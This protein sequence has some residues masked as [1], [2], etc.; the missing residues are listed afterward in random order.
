MSDELRDRPDDSAS[1]AL[2][3]AVRR[4]LRPLVRF[5]LERQLGF[6]FLANLLKGLYVEVAERDVALPGRRPTDSRISLLTGIHRREV[7]RLRAQLRREERIPSVLTLGALLVSRWT[8]EPEYLDAEGR[9]RALPRR[10]PAPAPSFESLVA[11]VSTDLPPRSVLDEWLRLGV[12]SED[13]N[14]M[15]RLSVDSFVP[16]KGFEEKVHFFGR[17]L[18]DHIAAGAHNILEAGP[19]FLDRSVYYDRLSQASADELARMAREEGA[20]LIRRVNRRALELQ[21]E[22]AEETR[23]TTHRMTLGAYFYA[24]DERNESEDDDSD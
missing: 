15:L 17:N 22:D 12:V 11:S 7:K 1:M 20:E 24:V 4:M 16:E 9:P 8:A 21:T 14:G 2:A 5:L 19:P 6:P 18:R 13:E 3:R 23:D 10:A